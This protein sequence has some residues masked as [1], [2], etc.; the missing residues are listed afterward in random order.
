MKIGI[1]FIVF[2]LIIL[3]FPSISFAKTN[4]DTS[5]FI[6]SIKGTTN[7]YVDLDATAGEEVS[8][9]IVL[10]NSGTTR[11]TNTLFISD[12][13]TAN[14]GGTMVLTPE[15]A[16]REK[17]GSWLNITEEEVT[18]DPGEKKVFEFVVSVPQNIK[19]GTHV[20]VIYLK[21]PIV[22]GVESEANKKGS[23][24]KINETYSLSSAVIIRVGEETIQNFIIEDNMEEKWVKNRDK[25]LSFYISNI[26]NTYSYPEANISI[27][28]NEDK[29]VYDMEKSFDI[30]YPDNTCRIDFLIP[31]DLYKQD[32]YNVILSLAY[33]KEATMSISREF[34]LSLAP[35]EI[36]TAL[37]EIAKKERKDNDGIILTEQL[38]HKIIISVFSVIIIVLL[39]TG[40]FR[41]KKIASKDYLIHNSF[42][43]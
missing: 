17:T 31:P 5:L 8:F 41:K 12:G 40:F 28:N 26:G 38:L 3:L 27:Y 15:E 9:S 30:V 7:T 23:S 10:Y 18:L 2:M 34:T 4:E 24:F 25:V 22:S 32:N 35:K 20:A 1:I 36:N 43:S 14:N 16:T 42:V 37:K 21:S 13:H 11:K 33:G 29:L 6:Y 19:S 39:L